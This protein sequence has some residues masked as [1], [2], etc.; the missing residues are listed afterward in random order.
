MVFFW[1]ISMPKVQVHKS[2]S[3]KNFFE[4]YWNAHLCL[5]FMSMSKTRS[6]LDCATISAG[7]IH[8]WQKNFVPDRKLL[9]TQSKNIVFWSNEKF[10]KAYDLFWFLRK[11]WT[12]F[13]AWPMLVLLLPKKGP[14]RA[15]FE[16]LITFRQNYSIIKHKV[17]KLNIKLSQNINL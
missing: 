14:Q 11:K 15:I 4:F 6:L 9:M 2:Y 16:S 5:I 10:L 8:F 12:W 1:D 13:W 3:Q 7:K 17:I